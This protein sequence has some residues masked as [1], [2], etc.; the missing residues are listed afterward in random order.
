[1]ALK[2][3]LS[4]AV[5]LEETYDLRNNPPNSNQIS[6]LAPEDLAKLKA[7]GEYFWVKVDESNYP[8]FIGIVREDP[9]FKQIFKKGDEI[10]FAEENIFDIRFSQWKTNEGI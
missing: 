7:N 9:V 3:K 6:F 5:Q 8:S 2:P 10:E 1:M 4:N